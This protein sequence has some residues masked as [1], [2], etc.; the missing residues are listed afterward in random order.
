[1]RPNR[2]VAAGDRL[3]LTRH[4]HHAQRILGEIILAAA[5]CALL[6]PAGAAGFLP[7]QF[8]APVALGAPLPAQANLSI[9]L[10]SPSSGQGPV[11][12][13]LTVGGSA[14]GNSQVA[15]GAASSAANC[16]NPT[17]GSSTGWITTFGSAP[18][19]SDGNYSFSFTWPSSLTAGTPYALCAVAAPGGQPANSGGVPASQP[20]TVRSAQPPTLSLSSSTVQVGQPFT[21]TGNNFFGMPT[22]NISINSVFYQSVQPDGNG[23]FIVTVTPTAAQ[24]GNT[25]I[26]AQSPSEGNSAPVLT[27][28][29]QITVLG[30][31]TVTPDP[32]PSPSP[33]VEATSTAVNSGGVGGS[34]STSS[35]GGG[36]LIIVLIIAILLVLAVI[37]G[38]ITFLVLRRRG[39]GGSAYP[40]GPGGP[41]SGGDWGGYPGRGTGPV[42]QYGY[43]Q[44]ATGQFGAAG[45]YG[46]TGAYP[47]PDPYAS[48]Q[49][50]G[51][52]NWDDAPPMG[53]GA[54]WDDPGGSA[55]GPDWQPRPMSGSQ[56]RYDDPS[57]PPYTAPGQAPDPY[58]GY[59]PPDPWASTQGGYGEPPR[60]SAPPGRGN[61]G[62]PPNPSRRPPPDDPWNTGDDEQGG[63]WNPGPRG[64]TRGPGGTNPTNQGW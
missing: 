11:G 35:G 14:G 5:L 38:A 20:Y 8:A 19:G 41:G 23:S 3:P 56:R 54:G 25:N 9:S 32:T 39:D 29:A 58:G 34:T 51:V 53:G 18:Q 44:S 1:M 22:I 13:K 33:S 21:I 10:F 46:P 40:G 2:G 17:A 62:Y 4:I 12:A 64:G 60:G 24:A 59:P 27:A 36:G 28:T 63:G 43:G 45:S 50:G 6:L 16:A 31:P 57:Y 37:G 30:A 49:M 42:P 7:R 47:Q 55:P 61:T 52:A 26:L 48:Q 15:I